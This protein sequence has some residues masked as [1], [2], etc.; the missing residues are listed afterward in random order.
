MKFS[1][2]AVLTSG[3][4]I[5]C[6]KDRPVD[7]LVTDSRKPVIGEG[8]VFF[9]IRGDRHDGH[10]YIQELYALGIR[11]FV[12][13]DPIPHEQYP[14]GN[15]LQVTSSL[16]AIQQ[17]AIHQ[18][19]QH[20]IPVLGITGSNGKTTIKEW[21]FQVLSPDFR[22]IKNPG[23]YNSQLGVSLSVWGMNASHELGLFEAGI[24]KTGEMERLREIIQPSLGIFTNLGSAH[25]EGFYSMREKADEKAKLFRDCSKTIYC[26][27]HEEVH[28]A[29]VR[30]GVPTL[31]WGRNE[32]ADI[33][34]EQLEPG[35]FRLIEGK[36]SFELNLPFSDRAMQENAFHVVAFL[37]LHGYAPGIIQ[38]RIAQLHAVPMRLELKQGVHRSQ[39]IDDSYNNDLAGLKISID[40]LRNQQKGKKFIIL[41]D[42][43]QS[44]LEPEALALQIRNLLGSHPISLIGIGP[45]LMEQQYVFRGGRFFPSTDAFLE[46]LD[47][48]LFADS[49]V[50]IKG[51]RLFQF[52]RIVRK[53]QRKV[54]GTVMEIDLTSMVHNLNYF[55][56]RLNPGTRIMGMVKAFA[57]GS[58]SEEVAN[59]LQ[60]HRVDY[61]GVAFADEGVDLRK[62]NITVPIMVMNPSE[63]S[64]PLMLQHHLEPEIYSPR[65]FRALLT[66]LQGRPCAIHI[67]LDTG[68]HRLGFGEDD[69]AELEDFLRAHPHVHVAS[70]F[71]HLSGADEK[72]HDGFSEEQ[73]RRFT[74]MADRLERGLGYKPLRHMLNSPGILRFPQYQFDMVRLGIGL[75]GIDPTEEGY[76]NLRPVVTLKTTIS[77]IKRLKAG[78]TVGYGR[79]GKV[80]KEST[81]A[82]L[83]IG[84][85]DG[86]SRRFSNGTGNVLIN[87]QLAPVKGNVC[88]DMTMVD[89]TGIPAREG[90][91]AIIFGPGLP[92]QQ[93]A[94][95]IETIP[96]EILTST[97]DRVK[98]VFY[99][100]SI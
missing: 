43:L 25:N 40:F 20:Q 63:E 70:L 44:G 27:D 82:T 33:R 28:E 97:S 59:L 74:A 68:M 46:Q 62:N 54:H 56:S 58:G 53:L 85:A 18:R 50:L 84:Y 83:A 9:A 32:A 91:E 1:Q 15:I 37:L 73:A 64:F 77:Q 14:D 21:L 93:V 86:F 35:R 81:V 79:R 57:Y 67:K 41:S 65:L 66:F 88:M 6:P 76:A 12:V 51:A 100:E 36:D 42:I 98:R 2:L 99:A 89:I 52:E 5:Q 4:L 92:I 13:E 30:T 78:D 49:V 72:T 61:L 29:L 95:W 17:L 69:L 10:R 39:L 96:Y 90:D 16:K 31:S 80:E 26:R 34:I 24:S 47:P 11:Q 23:S 94:Q 60:F 19:Q 3:K 48:D 38:E 7:T 8:S 55:K 45:M 71:T 22:I 87:G 75:Y